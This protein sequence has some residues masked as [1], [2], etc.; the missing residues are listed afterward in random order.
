MEKC[1][2]NKIKVLNF[3]FTLLI[4]LYHFKTSENYNIVFA[5]KIDKSIYD[6]YFILIER[7]G[8][9]AMTFF[10]IISGFLFYYNIDT[11]KDTFTKM[12]KRL[13]SLL[14]PY[15]TWTLIVII[16]NVCAHR[17]MGVGTEVE[18]NSIFSIVKILFL[19]PIDGPLWYM[20]ALL[21][22]M[23][24]SPILI[25]LKNKRMLSC[26]VYGIV[27]LWHILTAYRF[28]PSLN[29]LSDWWWFG[30]MIGYLPAYLLGSILALNCGDKILSEKY[31]TKVFRVCAIVILVCILSFTFTTKLF[32][33]IA[34]IAFIIEVVCIWLIIPSSIFKSKPKQYVK[35]SFIIY[36]MHQPILLPIVNKIVLMVI[37]NV[38]LSGYQFIVTKFVVLLLIVLITWAIQFVIQKLPKN[39]NLLFTGGR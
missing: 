25:K 1:V 32:N 23:L 22:F 31:N 12:K 7:I 3:I 30:N 17:F 38:S 10:F 11:V 39:V 36:A 37:G 4:V 8:F 29:V 19:T 16:F 35:T 21:I 27:L 15:L 34:N 26:V 6:W 14:L 28:I 18:I 24:L 5:S 9:V 33:N 20:L 13:K 2:S